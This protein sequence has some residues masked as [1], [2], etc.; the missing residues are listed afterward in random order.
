[1]DFPKP[2]F[3]GPLE[4]AVAMRYLVSR[5]GERF[6]SVIAGFSLAGIS[7]G[8]MTLIVVMSVMNGFRVELLDRIL[9][10]NGHIG[11]YAD[12]RPMSDYE[13]LAAAVSAMPGVASAVPVV[14]GQVLMTAG[15]GGGSGAVVRGISPGDLGSVRLVASN[16]TAGSIADMGADGVAIGSGIARRFGLS[17]G[18]MLTLV[19][20]DGAATAFGTVP[21]VKSYPVAAVFHAGMNEFDSSFVFMPMAAAQVFF[22]KPGAATQVEVVLVDPRDAGRIAAALARDLGGRGLRVLD[23]RESNNGFVAA[24]EVER[25]VMFLILSLIVVVAA[26]NVVS[27]LVMLVKDKTA[28]IAVLRTVGATGGSVMRVFVAVGASVGIAGTAAGGIMG[29]LLARNVDSRPHVAGG[30]NGPRAH[31]PGGLLPV[32]PAVGGRLGP[33]RLGAWHVVGAVVPGH[34]LSQLAR[35]APGPGRGPAA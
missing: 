8:V 17:P 21:R 11:I 9:G 5:R 18:G 4:R 13:E 33:G 7:L 19:S 28:D 3:F 12:G 23:W 29:I 6:V 2:P 14:E 22:Q 24:M 34:A 10:F 1:M 30:G 32:E 25:N 20:P 15:A 26:F 31:E 16:V 27:S 35:G